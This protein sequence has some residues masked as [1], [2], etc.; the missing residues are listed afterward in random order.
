[1]VVG[2]QA[3]AVVAG[4]GVAAVAADVFHPASLHFLAAADAA[5]HAWVSTHL[6]V[7]GQHFVA[8]ARYRLGVTTGSTLQALVL[9]PMISC[10]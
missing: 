7:A 3:V 8:G 1:M 6:D 5:A 9:M 4:A 10:Q 2:A